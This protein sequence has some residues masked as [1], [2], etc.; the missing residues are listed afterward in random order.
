MLPLIFPA[1]TELSTQ[2]QPTAND[3]NSPERDRF[4]FDSLM[5]RA[6]AKGSSCS[7]APHYQRAPSGKAERRDSGSRQDDPNSPSAT[8]QTG[9]ETESAQ[10]ADSSAGAGGDSTTSDG[11]DDSRTND[12]KFGTNSVVQAHPLTNAPVDPS[13]ITLAP[14]VATTD[15]SGLLMQSSLGVTPAINAA[16]ASTCP[17]PASA[18]SAEANTP[19]L[20]Q[21]QPSTKLPN[22]AGVPANMGTPTR[23]SAKTEAQNLEQPQAKPTTQDEKTALARVPSDPAATEEELDSQVKTRTEA[24]QPMHSLFPSAPPPETAKNLKVSPKS[25]IS[26]EGVVPEPFGT[27]SA[28]EEITMKKADKMLKSAGLTEQKLPEEQL[29][30]DGAEIAGQQPLPS[31]TPPHGIRGEPAFQTSSLVTNS[32]ASNGSASAVTS[33]SGADEARVRSLERTHDLVALHAIRLSNSGTDSLRVVVEPG[34]GTRLLL[35]LRQSPNGIEAQALLH[36]G[37]FEF[38]NQHW[39]QLQQRLESRGVHLGALQVGGQSNTDGQSQNSGRQSRDNS[40]KSAFAE[41]A[42]GGSMTESPSTKRARTR[43]HRGWETWA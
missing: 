19:G 14:G 7:S 24:A 21:T 27:G 17:L 1:W 39:T 28:Q 41:F 26:S 5:D 31:V 35:E 25:A 20:L 2:P 33:S 37:D 43:R 13:A 8:S 6:V 9:Q 22:E 23:R 38:M 32:D 3:Y 29:A 18:K 4:P 11:S 15:P 40:S 10:S 36:R 16:S 42:F 30:A 12:K 34:S